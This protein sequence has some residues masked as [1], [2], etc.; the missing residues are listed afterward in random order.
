[1]FWGNPQSLGPDHPY[2]P[3]VSFCMYC[4]CQRSAFILNHF[5]SV[6][7]RE[8]RTLVL[9]TSYGLF[10]QKPAIFIINTSSHD[11]LS[12]QYL[13]P[14]RLGYI[15]AT[16]RLTLS[17]LFVLLLQILFLNSS[18]FKRFPLFP[19]LTCLVWL[20]IVPTLLLMHF[21]HQKKYSYS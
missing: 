6:Q 16:Y 10:F 20:V 21:L 17:V 12:R 2:M 4:S 5:F 3:L 8:T 15:S 13:I 18:L 9:A 11:I 7:W 1:M 14:S 19:C